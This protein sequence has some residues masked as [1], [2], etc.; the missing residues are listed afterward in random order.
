MNV[1]WTL[2]LSLFLPFSLA[3]SLALT[4]F[5]SV[6]SSLSLCNWQNSPDP[7]SY[8]H[9][10]SIQ[11]CGCS[12]LGARGTTWEV[13]LQSPIIP[14]SEFLWQAFHISELCTSW[15]NTSVTALSET[16]YHGKLWRLDKHLQLR[17]HLPLP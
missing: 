9:P 17:C 12:D 3:L 2:P 5:L 4:L 14:Q 16:V 10:Y 13:R 11:S 15:K 6:S 1:L 7:H 8:W